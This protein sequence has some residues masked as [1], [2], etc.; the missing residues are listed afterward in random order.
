[1]NDHKKKMSDSIKCTFYGDFE[2][3]LNPTTYL[4]ALHVYKTLPSLLRERENDAVPMKVWLYPFALLNRKAAILQGE[5]H[6]TLITKA[7]A[8][9]E[10]LGN[11]EILCNDLIT[12]TKENDFLD[13]KLRMKTFQN[14]LVDYKVVFL[15]AMHKLIPANRGGTMEEQAL[16]DIVKI[17]HKSPFRPKK[18]NELLEYNQSE[19]NMLALYT[20]QVSGVPVVKHSAL[21]SNIL[22]D[23]SV[24][25]VVCFCFNSLKIED[26]YLSTLTKFLKVDEF[27]NNS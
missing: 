7:E 21:Y 22:I 6:K 24:D 13:V 9:L 18:L 17:H 4:E 14:L 25:D 20:Q 3:E 12:N 19:Q 1:M 8:V 23:P 10:E 16:A 5:I 26:P 2:L 27:E 11:A 15:K